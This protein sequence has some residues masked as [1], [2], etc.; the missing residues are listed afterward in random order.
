MDDQLTLLLDWAA[1]VLAWIGLASVVL[2]V[3]VRLTPWR[4]DDRLFG[5]VMHWA[6]LLAPAVASVRRLPAGPG[7]TV[8]LAHAAD[9]L[10]D[11]VQAERVK[12]HRQ[13][14]RATNDARQ[15]MAEEERRLSDEASKRLQ[16]VMR[17][18]MDRLLLEL[19]ARLERLVDE[20]VATVETAVAPEIAKARLRDGD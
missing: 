5:R 13:L 19:H 8:A 2:G 14:A 1:L 12:L 15:F 7:R 16:E 17:G 18:D 20:S 9:G 11:Q 10:L 4:W 6:A 3:A